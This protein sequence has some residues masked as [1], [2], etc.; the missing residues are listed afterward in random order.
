MFLWKCAEDAGDA[1]ERGAALIALYRVGSAGDRMGRV[2]LTNARDV[3][4][5]L[6]Q[7]VRFADFLCFTRAASVSARREILDALLGESALTAK[8][9][10]R[11]QELRKP[12][13]K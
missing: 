11:L 7:R 6:E 5:P 4:V 10:E 2:A 8:Q 9:R 1:V 12:L 3:A 13:G